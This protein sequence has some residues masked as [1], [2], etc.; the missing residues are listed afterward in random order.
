MAIWNRSVS[1]EYSLSTSASVGNRRCS[2]K[3]ISPSPRP[4]TFANSRYCSGATLESDESLVWTCRSAIMRWMLRLGGG[5]APLDMVLDREN[6][7]DQENLRLHHQPIGL[8]RN[9]APQD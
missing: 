4:E 5:V 3:Q 2:V 9:T 8:S 6:S 1:S 7:R